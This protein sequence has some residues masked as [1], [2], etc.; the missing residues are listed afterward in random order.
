M[1][2][3]PFASSLN[4]LLERLDQHQWTAFVVAGHAKQGQASVARL[5]E[6]TGRD[7]FLV[8]FSRLALR[9][10]IEWPEDN[11]AR[12]YPTD[13]VAGLGDGHL[14]ALDELVT[15]VAAWTVSL[16]YES[17]ESFLKD[18]LTEALSEFAGHKDKIWPKSVLDALSRSSMAEGREALERSFKSNAERLKQLR[19]I[20]PRL[21]EAELKNNRSLNLQLWF[22]VATEV[23][24]AVTHSN[25]LIKLRWTNK[26]SP[27]QFA[28]LNRC[29]PHVDTSDGR[30][31]QLAEKNA[32]DAV[33]LFGEYGYAIFKVLRIEAGREWTIWDDQSGAPNKEK[34]PTQ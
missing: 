25:F 30:D 3:G 23:R 12:Y 20:S 17:F 34:Q 7:D 4:R 6:R 15:R 29:F 27:E 28:I 26:W 11:W 14:A 2:S 5:K 24:H 19:R 32:K 1:I 8:A 31:L 22:I 13:G 21:E 10:L 33:Q 16:A 9:D 18:V